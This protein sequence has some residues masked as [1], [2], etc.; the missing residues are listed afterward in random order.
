[1]AKLLK[2]KWVYTNPG[3]GVS[4]PGFVEYKTTMTQDARGRRFIKTEKVPT[5]IT[6]LMSRND[7]PEEEEHYGQ[8]FI[9]DLGD[10]VVQENDINVSILKRL[11]RQGKIIMEDFALQAEY[12]GIE[13]IEEDVEEVIDNEVIVEEKVLP[14]TLAAKDDKVK[15][16]REAEARKAKEKAKAFEFLSIKRNKEDIISALFDKGINNAQQ[17]ID[18][19]DDVLLSIAGVGK[20]LILNMKTEAVAELEK[21]G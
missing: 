16:L 19:N 21:Q 10:F 2:G 4:I 18:A 1:M 20:T 14:E 6:V 13:Y 5:A 9:M 3:G 12:E 8:K 7:E 15:H 11:V 17:L